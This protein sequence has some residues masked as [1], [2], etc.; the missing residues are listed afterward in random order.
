[1][2][3]LIVLFSNLKGG[4]GKTTLSTLFATYC[5]EKGLPVVVLD[6]DTQ[7]SL[8][9][10]RA[11]DIKSDNSP[12]PWTVYPFRV[13]DT[14]ESKIRGIKQVPGI[15]L[16]DC[17]G[18]VDNPNL[19]FIFNAADIAV[20]PFRFDRM[21]VRETVTFAE[22]FRMISKAM[23]LFLPNMVTQYDTKRDA[24]RLAMDTAENELRKHGNILPC[25][26]EC[27]AVRDSN[28][29]AMNYKQ[30][31]AVRQAFDPIIDIIN[32]LAK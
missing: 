23:L 5:V 21:N 12:I 18:T 6:A 24:L 8:D 19:K 16:I 4:T 20:M 10:N 27:L 25:I 32:K 2:K 15:V 22:I 17:P 30:R 1:M 26:T 14:I 31:T 29:L 9:K 3:N 11:D 13:D 28:T 7:R